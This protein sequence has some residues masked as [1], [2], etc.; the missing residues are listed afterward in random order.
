MQVLKKKNKTNQTNKQKHIA[1]HKYF[2]SYF[3]MF[4]ISLGLPLATE[5]DLA[6]PVSYL[7]KLSIFSNL[8]ICTECQ[9]LMP[10]IW[11]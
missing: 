5:Q 10:D 1:L 2:N 6:F 8:L 11:E 4:Y 9:V 3:K 7:N